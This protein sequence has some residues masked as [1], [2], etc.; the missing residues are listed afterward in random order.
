MQETLKN[1]FVIIGDIPEPYFCDREVETQQI[2][3]TLTNEGNIVLMSPRRM[4]KSRLVKHVFKQPQ[5][6]E[7]YQTFYIDLLHTSSMREFAYTFGKTVFDQLKSR[8]EK[9]LKSLTL[10]LKSIAGTFG[11]DPLTGLPTFTLE[12][13]RI[14]APEYTLQEIMGWMESCDTPCIVCFDEF[15]R[16]NK[17]PDNKQG[18]VEAMLRGVIQHLRNVNF[19]FAGSEQHLLS[20]M[21][22][23]SAKP[24]Y[25][26]ADQLNLK[27]L[28]IDVYS[29]FVRS[30]MERYDK[31]IDNDA[32]KFYYE[33]FEGTT[34]C[35]QKMMHEA[36]IDCESGSTCDK[37]L[38][39]KTFTDMLE[40]AHEN[41]SK[42]LGTLT[43]PQKNALYAIAREGR[44][45]RVLS[46]A[47]IKR[48]AL[49][50]SSSMQS[51]IR[52]LTEMELIAVNGNT[53]NVSDIMMRLYITNILD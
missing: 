4:G 10:A 12:M 18:Q 44:A 46:A 21:F 5:I 51:S 23:S 29:D 3:R 25:N 17:Y 27:P 7:H 2:I 38:L 31:S 49:A 32:L 19:I 34:Y 40:E 45:E 13:G 15:Q 22:F 37:M 36:F 50:S 1:P 47:F 6:S 53:Y 33:K 20:E 42:L 28:E 43:E 39:D 26:S 35:L 11:F 9:M 16:I 24:F 14:Q 52:K 8:S 30:W 41:I 48:H